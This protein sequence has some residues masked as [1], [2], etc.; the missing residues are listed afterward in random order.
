MSTKIYNAYKVKGLSL[1]ELIGTF[2]VLRSRVEDYQLKVLTSLIGTNKELYI[3]DQNILEPPHL[4]L[5]YLRTS[6]AKGLNTPF[7]LEASVVLYT[8]PIEG[9][10][11]QF[12]GFPDA[13]TLPKKVFIDFHYQNQA[14]KP[15]QVSEQEW[16]HRNQIWEDIFRQSDIPSSV[17]LH[18]DLYDEKELWFRLF[19]MLRKYDSSKV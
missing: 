1:H 16:A 11:V 6:R 19:T 5:E 14:D 8:H 17:G 2:K 4:F 13:L 12:F 15:E 3:G 7:N 18:Y 9:M 10:L